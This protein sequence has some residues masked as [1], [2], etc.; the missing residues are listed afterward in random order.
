MNSEVLPQVVNFA[1]L[2][3]FL[4]IFGKKPFSTFLTARSEDI[5]KMIDEA[6]KESKE[7]TAQFEKAQENLTHQEAHAKKLRED[8]KAILARHREKTLDFAKAESGRI[9]KD[10]ELLGQGELHKKKEALQR[11]ICER[12]VALAE[13]YLSDQLET[14]DKEKLVSEYITLVGHGKA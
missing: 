3:G 13:K 10:G 7:V 1:V 5:K 8:A 6:E 9:V 11:E 2:V 4:G 14:K 12:S